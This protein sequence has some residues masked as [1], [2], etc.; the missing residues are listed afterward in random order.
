MKKS[1]LIAMMVLGVSFQV[2]ANDHED[3]MDSEHMEETMGE[4][5]HEE[6]ATHKKVAMSA[7]SAEAACKKEGK[8]GKDLTSCIKTKTSTH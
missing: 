3:E 7:K 6:D 8:K 4:E 5:S 1:L 2:Y